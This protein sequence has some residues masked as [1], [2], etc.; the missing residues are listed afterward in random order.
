[1]HDPADAVRAAQQVPG[2]LAVLCAPMTAADVYEVAAQ[3]RIVPRKSTSF[4]PKPRT[5]LVIRTFAES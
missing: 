4:G 1:M 2:T 5:G 3:G